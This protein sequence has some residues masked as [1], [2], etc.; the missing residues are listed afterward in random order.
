LRLAVVVAVA[1]EV[2]VKAF[3]EVDPLP[4]DQ[5]AVPGHRVVSVAAIAAAFLIIAAAGRTIVV[6]SVATCR[7]IVVIGVRREDWQDYGDDVRDD[8]RDWYN[9]RYRYRVGVS[10]SYTTFSSLS[11][12]TTTVHVDGVT[13]YRC[14]ND[15]YSRA[16]SGG[17]VTYIVVKAPAG[18]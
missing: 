18:Y 13:Y 3:P 15:W 17:N 14:D 2:V 6:I 5:F 10:I 1:V 12:T 9:D 4:A 8:R 11:C 7:T 16:Y